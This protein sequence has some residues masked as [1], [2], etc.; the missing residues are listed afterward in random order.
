MGFDNSFT[1]YSVPVFYPLWSLVITITVALW[2]GGPS[3]L[4]MA[5]SIS[6]L[7]ADSTTNHRETELRHSGFL[8]V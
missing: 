1:I 3:R 5:K 8:I 7:E 4:S 2:H 6:L